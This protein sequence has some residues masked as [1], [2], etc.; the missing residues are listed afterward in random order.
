MY[1]VT[2]T[3]NPPWVYQP[4]APLCD[5]YPEGV[6]VDTPLF[7]WPSVKLSPFQIKVKLQKQNHSGHVTNTHFKMTSI[8]FVWNSITSVIVLTLSLIPLQAT[9]LLI[10]FMH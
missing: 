3:C 4:A 9:F 7:W 6:C 5:S 1:C 2:V 10:N 8:A